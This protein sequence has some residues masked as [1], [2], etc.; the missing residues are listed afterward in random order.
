M[1]RLHKTKNG[2]LTEMQK[3][4][5]WLCYNSKNPKRVPSEYYL[6]HMKDYHP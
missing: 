1:S 5:L 3:Y 4:T 6:L 2:E